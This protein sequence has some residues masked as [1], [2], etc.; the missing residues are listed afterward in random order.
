VEQRRGK[1]G[2]PRWCAPLLAARGGQ[3][4]RRKQRAGAVAAVK[5]WA[6]QSGGGHSLNVGGAVGRLCPVSEADERAHAVLVLSN[7]S[8]TGSNL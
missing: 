7:L 8:K 5:P 1:G 6:W 4:W 3:R 2:A